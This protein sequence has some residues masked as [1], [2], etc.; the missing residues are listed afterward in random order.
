MPRRPKKPRS[1]TITVN[2]KVDPKLASEK[3]LHTNYTYNLEPECKIAT[4]IVKLRKHMKLKAE[5]ALFLFIEGTLASLGKRIGD[6][7]KKKLIC[8]LTAENAF[9]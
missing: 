3:G 8:V 9:G 2:V 4:L 5:E 6:Y 1:E 7:G